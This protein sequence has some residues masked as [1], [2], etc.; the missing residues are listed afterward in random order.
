MYVRCSIVRKKTKLQMLKMVLQ[1]M[2]YCVYLQISW[3]SFH[4]MSGCDVI[5][6][7]NSIVTIGTSWPCCPGVCWE[8][9]F[10]NIVSIRPNIIK[11]RYKMEMM[12]KEVFMAHYGAWRSWGKEATTVHFCA[13]LNLRPPEYETRVSTIH[14]EIT[15]DKIGR[16]EGENKNNSGEVKCCSYS[17][18]FY[19]HVLSFIYIA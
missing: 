10:N 14:S 19:T 8:G 16:G 12:W 17:F 13:D 11:E 6:K 4:L 3:V 1:T 15:F 18:P 2:C 9:L 5:H 7:I